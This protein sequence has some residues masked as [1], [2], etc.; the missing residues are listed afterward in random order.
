MRKKHHTLSVA[1]IVIAIAVC[2]GSVSEAREF[3]TY[4]KTTIRVLK[5]GARI[6]S[7]EPDSGGGR[8]PSETVS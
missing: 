7:G 2:I 1:A 3:R 6:S 8:S 5:P 4:P